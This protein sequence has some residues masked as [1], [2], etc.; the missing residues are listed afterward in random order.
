ME[1]HKSV[2]EKQIGKLQRFLDIHP[3]AREMKRALA[4]KLALQ[5]YA[6]RA[7]KEIINVSPGFVSKW[8]KRF[9]AEGIEGLRLGYKGAKKK[10]SEK[11]IEEV[12][13][14]ILCQDYWDIGDLEIHLIEEY[15]VVFEAAQSYYNIFKQ[16]RITRQKA[17][18]VN[19]RK[20][21]EKIDEINQEI[22]QLLSNYSEQMAA[23][24]IAVYAIDECHLLGDDLCG[25]VWGQSIERVKIQIENSRNRQTYYGA[26][27]ILEKEFVLEKYQAGNGENTVDFLKKLQ[28]INPGKKLVLFWDG[29]SY[30]RGQKMKDFLKSQN[31]DKPPQKWKIDCH[32]FAPYAP[33]ENPVEA[34]WLQLKSLLRRF[35]RF[36]KNFKVVN[37]IFQLLVELKLFSFPNINK[38]TAFS[39]II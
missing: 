21:Q 27:N 36:G 19:P 7:I 38:F 14:W 29:A 33:E 12:V 4:V 23:Q 13:K 18:Q 5:G 1:E 3:D 25:Q 26:L 39:Q 15:D 22:Q 24:E 17:E 28:R 11:E 20:D 10:L 8:K 6:Y 9:K 2:V 30:H 35:Y 16:A 37:Q 31:Q 34:V 32:L